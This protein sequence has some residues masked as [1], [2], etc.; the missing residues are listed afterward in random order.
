[1]TGKRAMDP[2]ERALFHKYSMA[3]DMWQ[4]GYNTADIARE[5]DE[6]E[7]I[8]LRYVHHWREL[9]RAGAVP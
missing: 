1:M 7:S 6:H 9:S 8:A 3:L 4:R 2:E 5:I